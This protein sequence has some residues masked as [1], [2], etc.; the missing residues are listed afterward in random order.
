MRQLQCYRRGKSGTISRDWREIVEAMEVQ[1]GDTIHLRPG[2]KPLEVLLSTSRRRGGS[3]HRNSADIANIDESEKSN[4]KKRC[5]PCSR[6]LLVR[7]K[8]RRQA[9]RYVL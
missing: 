1:V 9:L 6:G 3:L 5:H 7:A 4:R 2:R 8:K